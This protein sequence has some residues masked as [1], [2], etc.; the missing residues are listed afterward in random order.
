VYEGAGRY[1]QTDLGSAD[2][3]LKSNGKSVLTFYEA[4]EHARKW[5]AQ[6]LRALQLGAPADLTVHEAL[7]AYLEWYRK[8]RR[9]I[10]ETEVA[11]NAHIL[12]KLGDLVVRDLTSKQIRDWHHA[13]AVKARRLRTKIGSGQ[14]YGEKPASEEEKRARRSTANRILTI[15]KAALNRAFE[16]ELVADDSAWRKVRPF[17]G[18]DEP[19]IRYLTPAE[20]TR[21]VNASPAPFR[22]LIAGALHTGARYSELVGLTIAD[23]NSAEWDDLFSGVERRAQSARA[24]YGGGDSV[25]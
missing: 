15:L 25:V 5:A 18:A 10:K 3:N 12:P 9:A 8:H 24:A 1:K 22:N 2:D 6:E 14:A 7:G 11:V 23:F 4:Q 21:L 20:S 13:L 19:V 16:D 17:K